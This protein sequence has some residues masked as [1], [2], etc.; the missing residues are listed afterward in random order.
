MTVIYCSAQEL[1]NITVMGEYFPSETGALPAIILKLHMF[2]YGLV[3]PKPW[4]CPFSATNATTWV[5]WTNRANRCCGFSTAGHSSSVKGKKKKKKNPQQNWLT[6][7]LFL[8]DKDKSMIAL[9]CLS[10]VGRLLTPGVLEHFE[11]QPVL[12]VLQL[13]GCWLCVL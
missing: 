4:W 10:G 1:E 2:H 7:W 8:L 6:S 9:G 3:C 5:L 11:V 12:D 13:W